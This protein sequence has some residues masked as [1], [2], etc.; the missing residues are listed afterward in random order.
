MGFRGERVHQITRKGTDT[1]GRNRITAQYDAD[2][3]G[4]TT[5]F[6]RQIKRKNGYKRP[7]PEVQEKV[8]NHDTDVTAGKK[9]FLI[10]CLSSCI[11]CFIP[12]KPH[13]HLNKEESGL[14]I[15]FN[16]LSCMS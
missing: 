11:I 12:R 6:I 15:V 10:Q 14:T 1:E 2:N 7:E 9:P 8:S 13:V 3:T 4:S 16:P 5:V